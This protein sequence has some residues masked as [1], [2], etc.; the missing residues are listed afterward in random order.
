MAA[1]ARA[2][3]VVVGAAAGLAAGLLLGVA[4]AAVWARKRLA[5]TLAWAANQNLPRYIILVRHGESQGN[6]DRTVYLS[7]PDNLIEVTDLGTKQAEEAGRRVRTL[8][9]SAPVHMF[10][11]PFQR[12]L[13]TARSIRKQLTNRQIIRTSV[14]P[15]IRE[16][17]CRRF[18]MA[19]W[20]PRLASC[21]TFV[22]HARRTRC[23]R[24]Q[25]FGNLQDGNHCE[26]QRVQE[27]VGRF[28]YR[29][30]TGE[31]GADVYDRVR[32]WWESAVL[33][34]N[35]QP[36]RR[37]AEVVLIVTHGL[38]MRLI[39]MQL[40]GWSPTTFHSVWNAANCDM[41]VLRRCVNERGHSPY[42]LDPQLGDS[43]QSSIELL[44]TM[45]GGERRLVTLRDYLSVPSP[46]T[47]QYDVVKRM[48]S[49]QLGI[50]EADIARIDFDAGRFRKFR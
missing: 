32:Q 42:V 46:R 20:H 31:S 16:Q 25:E 44:I 39:L 22:P 19:P 23:A 17:V 10:V 21:A 2:Q 26:L 6:A 5:A 43:P 18:G 35:Q 13:Q 33:R 3:G 27:L 47:L 37:R 30:P 41:Y 8:I 29:Y 28:W 7:K 9:G 48:L 1:P 36:H 15:R 38:T 45:R 12:T 24:V 49:V 34:V 4:I 40:Y 14:D 50:P 11:S